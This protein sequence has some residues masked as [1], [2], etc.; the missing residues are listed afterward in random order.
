MKGYNRLDLLKFEIIIRGN[1]GKPKAVFITGDNYKH[2]T[3]KAARLYKTF[4]GV[5]NL[6]GLN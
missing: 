1:D 5:I 6:I 4:T 2:A 3:E